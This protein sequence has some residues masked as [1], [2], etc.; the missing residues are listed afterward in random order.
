MPRSYET[1][2]ILR[3]DVV[4][5]SL[6]QFLNAQKGFLQEQGVTSI[7]T[8]IKGKR[9]FTFEIK[10]YREGLYV[11]MN[12]EAEP[13]AVDNWERGMRINEQVLRFMRLRLD[14]T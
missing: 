14:E 8:Q 1:M 11:Q 7:E 10:G 4:E 3:P 5:D 13:Q 9:R 6:E 2:L 12:Y